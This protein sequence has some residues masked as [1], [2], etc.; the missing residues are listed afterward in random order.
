[1]GKFHEAIKA[2]ANQSKI[3]HYNAIESGLEQLMRA[4]GGWDGEEETKRDAT[5][6]N[7]GRA[8][9]QL[10]RGATS[11]TAIYWDDQHVATVKTEWDGAMSIVT[12]LE[13]ISG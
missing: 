7:A 4:F 11:E 10:V 12:T 5:E 8:W 13:W 6:R 9:L 1:M 2:K 3:N